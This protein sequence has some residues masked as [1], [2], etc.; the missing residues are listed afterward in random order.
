M[1]CILHISQVFQKFFHLQLGFE[2]IFC[3]TRACMEAIL[4]LKVY[5]YISDTEIRY[6]SFHIWILTFLCLGQ[7][8]MGICFKFMTFTS[9][10]DCFINPFYHYPLCSSINPICLKKIISHGS[11]ELENCHVRLLLRLQ[12]CLIYCLCPQSFQMTFKYQ[13][14]WII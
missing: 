10:L 8:G 1:F 3:R 13:N 4:D 6:K 11:W 2:C 7:V 12:S 14:R 9:I 5:Q